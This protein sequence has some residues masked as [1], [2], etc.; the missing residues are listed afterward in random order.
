MTDET[1]AELRRFFAAMVRV[2]ECET[3][4]VEVIGSEP[5]GNPWAM[6]SAACQVR[7]SKAR[8]GSA[9]ELPSLTTAQQLALSVLLGDDI[10]LGVLLSACE[11]AGVFAD[12]LAG[13]IAEKARA[14]ERERIAAVCDG[15]AEA[16]QLGVLSGS[17]DSR[18][19]QNVYRNIAATARKLT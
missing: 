8:P 15:C 14:E 6:V 19:R 3:L 18:T 10:P 5:S 11:D 16:C 17:D 9:P 1:R 2:A 7:E 4:T 12:G 13:E